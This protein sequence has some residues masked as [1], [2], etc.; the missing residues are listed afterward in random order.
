MD[1]LYKEIEERIKESGYPG[2]INGFDIYNEICDEMDDKEIGTYL[3]MKKREDAVVFEYQIQ[4]MEDEFNLSF[5]K[6]NDH[7]T[8][9]HIDFDA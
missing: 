7:G 5:I 2:M 3:I 9:Y 4:I 6:I 8:E 1:E